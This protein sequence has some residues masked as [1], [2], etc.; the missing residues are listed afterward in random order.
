MC[1]LIPLENCERRAVGTGRI[2]H[3][4]TLLWSLLAVFALHISAALGPAIP[5]SAPVGAEKFG[6]P[7]AIAGNGDGY[8][9]MWMEI[10]GNA[11]YI[12]AARLTA[13]GETLDPKE[14]IVNRGGTSAAQVVWTGAAWVVAWDA[15][16]TIKARR[17]AADGTL[18]D[19][20]PKEILKNFFYENNGISMVKLGTRLVFSIG[21]SLISTTIDLG[22]PMPL[23]T[24]FDGIHDFTLPISLS[25]ATD[26]VNV[27]IATPVVSLRYGSLLRF[28]ILGD[29]GIAVVRRG[30]VSDVRTSYGD[31]TFSAT[32]S[33]AGAAWMLTFDRAGRQLGEPVRI[34]PPET[35]FIADRM[36]LSA[37]NGRLVA[38]LVGGEKH[39]IALAP[40][41]QQSLSGD[42]SGGTSLV[43]WLERG[44]FV[45]DLL[46]D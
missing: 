33:E 37:E 46:K 10:R 2:S 31:G 43:T 36:E 29:S 16:G 41:E 25:L 23:R 20:A 35:R 14:I 39:P 7:L 24:S 18:I 17:I 15:G 42:P 38:G 1:L 26:G 12:I 19:S 4:R 30:A 5:I 13:A 8:L 9:A 28:F 32:W 34:P 22:D 45:R 44:V 40:A 21:R 3:M 27:F 11:P 6:Y